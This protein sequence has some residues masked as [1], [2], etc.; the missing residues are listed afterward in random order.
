M[1][2]YGIYCGLFLLAGTAGCLSNV[3]RLAGSICR[4]D[5]KRQLTGALIDVVPLQLYWVCACDAAEQ[6]LS[7]EDKVLLA[8]AASE[9][10]VIVAKYDKVGSVLCHCMYQLL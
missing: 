9:R 6:S 4:E 1:I 8:Q 2:F 10:A 7:V 3:H 5:K